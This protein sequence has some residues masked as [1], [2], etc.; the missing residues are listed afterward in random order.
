MKLF[1]R[2]VFAT[3]SAVFTVGLLALAT[4][5]EDQWCHT[6]VPP[7]PF[8]IEVASA[9][10]LIDCTSMSLDEGPYL[11]SAVR[12][13]IIVNAAPGEAPTG[14]ILYATDGS[15]VSMRVTSGVDGPWR[16][17]GDSSALYP[18]RARHPAGVCDRETR[19]SFRC[20]SMSSQCELDASPL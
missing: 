8:E 20:D 6:C 3:L 14:E 11:P 4:G 5:P 19:V 13:Q 17:M 15:L 10:R 9:I 2:S 7:P 16:Q 1:R 12:N 18:L